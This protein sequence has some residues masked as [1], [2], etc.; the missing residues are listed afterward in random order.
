MKS[1]VLPARRM[2][3]LFVSLAC[4]LTAIAMIPASAGDE[5]APCP[6]TPDCPCPDTAK[7][8]KEKVRVYTNA[9]LQALEPIPSQAVPIGKQAQ[10]SPAGDDGSWGQVIEFIE[11]ERARDERQREQQMAYEAMVR[12]EEMIQDQLERPRYYL[13]MPY[14]GYY[15]GACAGYGCSRPMPVPTNTFAP[16][17]QRGIRTSVDLYRESVYNSAVRRANIHPPGR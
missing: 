12:R 2:R 11:R 17:D 4:C 3:Y 16:L 9:D 15:P 6:K 5:A 8:P 1:R 7:K 10:A 14:Y 13:P